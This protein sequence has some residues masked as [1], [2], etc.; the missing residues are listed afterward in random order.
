[1]SHMTC[2]ECLNIYRVSKKNFSA[3]ISGVKGFLKR[4]C[5][6]IC[7]LFLSVILFFCYRLYYLH[8][9]KDSVSLVCRLYAQ[10]SHFILHIIH[11]T[12][13]IK[14]ERSHNIPFLKHE[15]LCIS[16][17]VLI[18]C[19][20]F[21]FSVPHHAGIYF[22]NN[23]IHS[24]FQLDQVFIII[25]S[26]NCQFIVFILGL[27]PQRPNIQHATNFVLLCQNTYMGGTSK[28]RKRPKIGNF[29]LYVLGSLD[30][31]YI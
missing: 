24:R 13:H 31:L 4:P 19:I 11:H 26:L 2:Y 15:G 18:S 1:M 12:L 8:M 28:E 23:I 16:S 29:T 21:L 5:I 30:H 22:A 9:S 7:I 25:N 3:T 10:P 14:H 17:F 27:S 20:N 6:Y